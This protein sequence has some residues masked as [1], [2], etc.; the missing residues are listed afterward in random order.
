MSIKVICDECGDQVVRGITVSDYLAP[1]NW[2]DSWTSKSSG[3]WHFCSWSC[4][5]CAAKKRAE[6]P[7]TPPVQVTYTNVLSGNA[8]SVS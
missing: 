6:V 5:R 4:V 2:S 7:P 1:S 8:G 3:P